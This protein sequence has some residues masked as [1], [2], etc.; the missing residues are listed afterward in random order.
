MSKLLNFLVLGAIFLVARPGTSA[1]RAEI[2]ESLRPKKFVLSI[3]VNKFQSDLWHD[4]R[5][6]SKD[7]Q[8]VYQA[9]TSESI[10]FDGGMLVTE[11][12]SSPTVSKAEIEQAFERLYQSNR[13]DEDMI[14]VYISSHGTVAYKDGGQTLGRYIITSDTDPKN[15]KETAIDYDELMESFSRLKS[16][17]KV[18]IL[19]FCHSGVGKSILTPQMKRAL[20][21]L[22]SAYFQEPIYERAEGSIVLTAS[23]WKEPALE[24]SNLQNDVYTHFLLKGLEQD[25]NGDGAVSIT[26]AHTFASNMTYQYTQGRQ[27]PSAIMEL[28]GADPMVVKGTIN[29]K[30]RASLYSLMGR[31][32]RLLVSVDGKDM[33][34]LEKG[35]VVPEGKVRL[36]LR[37]P[38]SEKVVADRVVSFEAGR[39]YSVANYLIPRLPHTLTVGSHSLAFAQSNIREGYAPSTIHGVRLQYRL[40]EAIDIYDLSLGLSYLPSISETITAEGRKFKQDR[41]IGIVSASLGIRHSLRSLTASDKSLRT[42]LKMGAGPSVMFVKRDVEEEAFDTPNS[43]TAVLGGTALVGLDMILPYHLVKLGVDAELSAYQNFTNESDPV[44]WSASSSIYMGT[45]W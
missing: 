24:D 13:N 23:G 2:E 25:Q 45:F 26:E 40:D 33:G 21:S 34:A 10:G 28:L 36:T 38:E 8:D 7:A 44:I 32:S 43:A 35:I 19:A 18:L 5:Y 41:Q 14:V 6:A 1:S 42:E 11:T 30:S 29:N 9:F 20:A 39:E 17:K 16:R 37:D 4:L 22:K 15:L 3:G 12:P 27:R 31:F